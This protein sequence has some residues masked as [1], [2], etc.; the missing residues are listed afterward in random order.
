MITEKE[1]ISAAKKFAIAI[2]T[3]PGSASS[4]NAEYWWTYGLKSKE[5]KEYHTQNMYSEEEVQ[6]LIHSAVFDSGYCNLGSI[7]PEDCNTE[8]NE[9]ELVPWWES[10]KKNQ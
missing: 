2:H 1:I 5:A 8:V 7:D 6:S 10:H 4:L 3:K 9:D